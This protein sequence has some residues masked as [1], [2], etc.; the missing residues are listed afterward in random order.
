MTTVRHG[1]LAV[2]F[3]KMVSLKRAEGK[4]NQLDSKNP[5]LKIQQK[6]ANTGCWTILLHISSHHA[7]SWRIWWRAHGS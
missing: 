1:H 3:L 4:D 2:S 7:F 5:S 6:K